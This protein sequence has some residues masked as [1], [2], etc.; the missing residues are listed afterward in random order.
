M[1]KGYISIIIPV[2]NGEKYIGRCIESVINQSYKKIDIIL[3]ND[4]S[5]DHSVEIINQYIQKKENQIIFINNE[6]TLGVAEARNQGLKYVET[7]YVLFLDCDDWLDLNCL[8]RAINKFKENPEVDIVIW[9]I[10][11]AYQ[12]GQI[13]PRYS[14]NYDNCLTNKMALSLLSHS[15]DNEYFL[16]PLLGCKLIKKALLD[17]NNIYFPQ[18]VFEDDMFTFLAFLFSKKIALVVGSCLYYYQ[19]PNSLTHHFSESYIE[20]FFVT[21]EILYNYIENKNKEVYYKY[22][23]KSLKSMINCMLNNISD[24]ETQAQFKAKIFK[25]FHK[26][27]KLDEYY[28]YSFSLTI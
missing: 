1:K 28:K 11:T 8:E 14:Y 18:T 22:L 7:E 12:Y 4:N 17:T 9:E 24:F 13:A 16:S 5:D 3:I 10:K 21:F 26:S 15:I 23:D 2:Y 19:H 6:V 20:D 27:I 25:Y